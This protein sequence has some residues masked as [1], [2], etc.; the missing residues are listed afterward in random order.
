MKTKKQTTNN[1]NRLFNSRKAQLSIVNI[2]FFL[3]LI[4]VMAVVSPI[5]DEAITS[6]D[7]Y[8]NSSGVNR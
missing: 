2:L 3:I 1:S 8:S 6:T 7:Y 5:A 4:I